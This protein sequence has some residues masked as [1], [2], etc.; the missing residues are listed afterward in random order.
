[1]TEAL[2]HE[3]RRLQPLAEGLRRTACLVE[4][5]DVR[6]VR[7]ACDDAYTFMTD[8]LIPQVVAQSVALSELIDG[9]VSALSRDCR[10]L[11]SL[12][13]E[14]ALQRNALIGQQSAQ[15]AD[16]LR[17]VLFGLYALA[18]LQFVKAEEVYLPMVDGLRATAIRR[19]RDPTA[20]VPISR[21]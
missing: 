14:L 8:Q 21:R 16:D 17:R 7:R 10:E 6:A 18:R 1:M 11:V 4:K 12:T 5:A 19:Q 13:H 9:E 15:Q 2:R 20:L 3:F